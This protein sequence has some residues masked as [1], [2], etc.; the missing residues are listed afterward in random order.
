MIQQSDLWPLGIELEPL[1]C[2]PC[3]TD[4]CAVGYLAVDPWMQ[5][6]EAMRGPEVLLLIGKPGEKSPFPN[7]PRLVPRFVRRGVHVPRCRMPTRWR[8]VT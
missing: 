5:G 7:L 2:A 8:I 6:K 1:L 3:P 4:Y